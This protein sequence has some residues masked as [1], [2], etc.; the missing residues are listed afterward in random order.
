MIKLNYNDRE[1]IQKDTVFKTKSK[2][3]S[4]EV[5]K[6]HDKVLPK[7]FYVKCKFPIGFNNQMVIP[8]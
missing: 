3:L 1:I 2:K 8:N 5:T 4:K 6:Q 7:N